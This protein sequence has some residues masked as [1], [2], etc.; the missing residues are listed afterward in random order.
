[1]E[2]VLFKEEQRFT[3]WWLWFLLGSALLG[4]A[5]PIASEFSV[6]SWDTSSESFLRIILYGS[7]AV[8]FI[9]AGLIVLVLSRLKTKIT[10]DGIVITFPPLKRKSY[11]IKVQEIERFEIRK[12]RARREY[13]GYGFRSRRRSGRAYTISGNIGLQL[14]LKNG[15]K[16]LIG[17]QKKQ[18]IEFAMCKIVGESKKLSTG[19]R[20]SQE[21]DGWVGKKVKKILIVFAIEL[22]VIILIFGIIQL[23][24]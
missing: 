13:G 21:V 17:T 19:E 8:F 1:M 16:L 22:V 9:V 3:Q 6:Q 20:H 11:R 2:K 10:Y 24:K 5:I 4:I 7:V 18:A 14:Y 12:Y 23:L 15:K